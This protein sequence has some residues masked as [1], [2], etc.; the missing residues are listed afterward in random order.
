LSSLRLMK[1]FS[2][3]FAIAVAHA[4]SFSAS[5]QESDDPTAK[6]RF[7]TKGHKQGAAMRA[8][9]AEVFKAG[10]A[11]DFDAFMAVAADPYI[12]HSPDLPDGWKPVWDLLAKRPAGFSSKPMKW[13]GPGGFVDN[14]NMLV[15][16]REVNRGD[17][18]P[19]SKIVD[20]MRFDDEGKY[21]EHW[22]IRQAIS[23][24]TVSGHSE[25]ETAK[26]Y[27]E[28]PVKYSEEI[29]EANKK[30]VASF[31]HLAFNQNKLEEALDRYVI[32]TYIQ[33]NP[34]IA[35]GTEAVK[36]VFAAGKIPKLSYEI[37]TLVAQNDIVVAFSK[38]TSSAGVAAVVD[39]LRVRDGKLVEHWDVVQ[40]VPPD[41]KMPH[42]NGMF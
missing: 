32:D 30:T 27:T 6:I 19:R 40:P 38:V 18:T 1:R 21:A 8:A 17:G 4:F 7:V 39:I 31:L 3:L 2:Y 22:D 23:E 25:T 10:K 41:D 14:G 37:Q 28:K 13:L 36:E 42:K 35:D 5:A 26:T 20:V 16:F 9:L 34:M 11:K 24:K 12:Q 15:M 33:H 29:E